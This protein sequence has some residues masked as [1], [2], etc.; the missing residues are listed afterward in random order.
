MFSIVHTPIYTDALEYYFDRMCL[1][2]WYNLCLGWVDLA[3][4]LL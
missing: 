1:A 2:H 3:S 4:F